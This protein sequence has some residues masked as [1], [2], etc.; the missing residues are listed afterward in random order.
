MIFVC[1]KLGRRGRNRLRNDMIVD[2][3]DLLNWRRLGTSI[4][5]VL[6]LTSC[7]TDPLAEQRCLGKSYLKKR[8]MIPAG[9]FV[10]GEN[11][12]Y[13]EEGPPRKI[14]VEAFEMDIHEVTNGQ[15]RDFISKTGYRTTAEKT[16]PPLKGA[17]PEMLEPGS[18]TFTVPERPGDGWWTW[19]PG[20][21]WTEPEGPGSTITGSWRICRA[22]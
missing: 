5:I 15:F 16:P 4:V 12:R 17:P 11:P 13:P 22:M 14:H 7:S 8:I 9:D 3:C 19:T 21:R 20:A 2:G 10:M 18:A 6:L 1:Q